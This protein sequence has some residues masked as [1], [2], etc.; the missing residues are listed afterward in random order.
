MHP[1]FLG[2]PN[3]PTG[4]CS[5]GCSW[6]DV[7]WH[8]LTTCTYSGVDNL[9]PPKNQKKKQKGACL[10]SKRLKL[11]FS[12]ETCLRMKGVS[13]EKLTFS[14]I[15][16]LFGFC[17]TFCIIT[18]LLQSSGQL[19]NHK[20]VGCSKVEARMVQVGEWGGHLGQNPR[21]M[22]VLRGFCSSK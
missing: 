8:R 6:S 20:G 16:H 22:H 11:C 21:K 7:C 14:A 3:W 17:S 5:L 2:S 4:R 1:R 18:V 10:Y 19:A 12:R 9:F 15:F 13:Y